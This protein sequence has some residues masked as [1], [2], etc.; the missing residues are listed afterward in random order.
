M[1]LWGGQH[2]KYLLRTLQKPPWAPPSGPHGMMSAASAI[3]SVTLPAMHPVPFTV[4]P[5]VPFAV[6]MSAPILPSGKT[7]TSLYEWH[8]HG[9]ISF[10]CGYVLPLSV[11]A[12]TVR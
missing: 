6:Q 7:L 5:A 3:V 2:N 1:P 10:L 12:K 9:H 4:H 11:L 8:I